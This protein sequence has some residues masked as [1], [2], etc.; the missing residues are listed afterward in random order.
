MVVAVDC[1]HNVAATRLFPA[2]FAWSFVAGFARNFLRKFLV[3]CLSVKDNY[4]PNSVGINLFE[5]QAVISKTNAVV[6]FE[7][8]QLLDL[9]QVTLN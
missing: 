9:F 2:F 5:S 6:A 3:E 7:P 8:G 4:K 1:Y